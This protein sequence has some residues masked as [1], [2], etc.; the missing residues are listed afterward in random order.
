MDELRAKVDEARKAVDTQVAYVVDMAKRMYKEIRSQID[1]GASQNEHMLA[2]DRWENT[3]RMLCDCI[4]CIPLRQSVV[5][6]LEA[7]Q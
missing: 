2:V 6:E 3:I 5:V 4:E 1:W 7:A